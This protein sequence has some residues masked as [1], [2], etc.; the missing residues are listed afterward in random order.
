VEAVMLVVPKPPQAIPIDA[1]ATPIQVLPTQQ[2]GASTRPADLA[3]QSVAKIMYMLSSPAHLALAV[4][5]VVA[6][7]YFFRRKR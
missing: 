4:G 5:A 2:T 6:A 7:V 3:A 1:T